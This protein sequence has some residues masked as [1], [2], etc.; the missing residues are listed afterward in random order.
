MPYVFVYFFYIIV[1]FVL[2]TIWFLSFHIVW[3]IRLDGWWL[4]T[5]VSPYNTHLS[6]TKLNCCFNFQ[7]KKCLR[8]PVAWRT[9]TLSGR[10]GR[11]TRRARCRARRRRARR[12]PSR[13]TRRGRTASGSPRACSSRRPS[14]YRAS[15]P[16]K[17]SLRARIP[18]V[19]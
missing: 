15:G 4:V 9:R 1:I 13:R 12:A 16:A 11:S 18:F 3:T 8:N 10:C 5:Q 17:S 14:S 2:L 7:P 6:K 19:S